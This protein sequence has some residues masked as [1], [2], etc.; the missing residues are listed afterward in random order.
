MKEQK[1]EN[2]FL[3]VKPQKIAENQR[4]FITFLSVFE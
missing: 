3:C 1:M 2:Y 4:F